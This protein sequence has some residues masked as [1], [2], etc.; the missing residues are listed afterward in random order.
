MNEAKAKLLDEVRALHFA[1]LETALYLDGHPTDKEALAYFRKMRDEA[2][3]KTDVYESIYGP[4]TFMNAKA[5][6][7]WDWVE[8]PWPWESEE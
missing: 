2:K 1:T 3:K 4:L 7:S 8:G 5:E 6:G